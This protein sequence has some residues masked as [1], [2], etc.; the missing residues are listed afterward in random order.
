VVVRQ[1]P[2]QLVGRRLLDVRP[3]RAAAAG[4][5]H[6]RSAIAFCRGGAEQEEWVRKNEGNDEGGCRGALVPV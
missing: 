3:G 4:V 6:L 1:R 2:R 5:V